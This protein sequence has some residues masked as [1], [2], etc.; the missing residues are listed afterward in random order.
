[1]FEKL[2]EVEQRY[3]ELNSQ[4]SDPQVMANPDEFRKIAK[5]HAHIQELVTVFAR[6]SEVGNEIEE[7]REMLS[8]SE[9]EIRQ[10][11]RAESEQL[12]TEQEQL[13]QRLRMLLVPKDPLDE[14]NI[15][16]EIRAGTGGDEAALFAA[17]LF[18]MYSRYAERQGWRVDIS[19]LNETDHGGIKEVI[20]LIE[21]NDVYS[22]LKYEAGTHRVQRVP[23]T[24]S[25]GRIHTSAV[26]VA[27][28]PEADELDVDCQDKDIKIDVYRASGAGGQHVN[29]TDSAVRATH[30]PTGVVVTCQDEKSQHKNRAKALK[31]LRARLFEREREIQHKAQESER[32]DQVG[33]G[34]R[35][36]RIRTY[37]FPQSRVTDHR[38]GFTTHRLDDILAGNVDE[39]INPLH[40]FYQAELLQS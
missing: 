31:E 33:S 34:D 10:M 9:E 12:K 13:E 1:M 11:A 21:G 29:T 22:H 16:L 25:Q 8:D 36:E 27:I 30:I 18:R 24:E 14:K 17:D 37:N 2:K 28:L 15:Y 39:L 3:N 20:A 40:T 32:R 35:S 5:E 38:I 26:T 7:N 23:D 4:L 19:R 6:Y